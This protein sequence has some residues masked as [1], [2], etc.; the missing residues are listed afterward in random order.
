RAIQNQAKVLAKA[1]W[2]FQQQSIFKRLFANHDSEDKISNR[3]SYFHQRKMRLLQM[4]SELQEAIDFTPNTPAEK[5]IL[6]KELRYRKK[7]LQAQKR[8]ESEAIASIRNEARV[9][10]VNAGKSWL[11]FYDSSLA[12]DQRRDIRYAKEAA[13]KPYEDTKA[14]IARQ[15]IKIEK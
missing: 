9:Q 13:L 2:N 1:K 11:G 10:S 14:A 5:E 7:E 15:L 6:V 4:V 8:E 12:S 3:L